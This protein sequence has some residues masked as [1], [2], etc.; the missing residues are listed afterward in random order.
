MQSKGTQGIKIPRRILTPGRACLKDIPDNLIFHLKRFDYDLMN[1]TRSKVNDYFEFPQEID[2]A[3]YNVEYLKDTQQVPT[4]DR[5]ILVGILVHSGNAEAGHY[6]SYIRERPGYRGTWVE[7]ND[8]D[9]TYFDP[10]FIRDQCFGGLFEQP[11]TG[12]QYPKTWNAYMLF[13]QRA[14]SMEA[15]EQRYPL[16]NASSPVRAIVPLELANHLNSE[17]EQWIR[18]FCLFD[19]EY[20]AFTRKVVEHYRKLRED[21]CSED[22]GLERD[23][24]HMIVHQLDMVFTREKDGH[25]ERDLILDCLW[26]MVE[27]CAL[28][29]E[30][31]LQRLVNDERTLRALILR[32]PDDAF[33][34][35]CQILLFNSLKLLK[36]RNL[37]R[38]SLE[39]DSGDTD[40]SPGQSM[41]MY[42][43][44]EPGL[45]Q[46]TILALR[47]LYSVMHLHSRMWDEYYLLL[48]KLA[49]I[50]RWEKSVVYSAGFLTYV[51]QILIGESRADIGIQWPAVELYLKARNRR[52]ISFKNLVALLTLLLK[53]AS[54]LAKTSD[55]DEVNAGEAWTYDLS[56][57]EQ[58]IIIHTSWQQDRPSMKHLTF[59]QGVFAANNI[60]TS[61][62]Q[63]L[64][65]TLV[66]DE[67]FGRDH[68]R[69]ICNTILRGTVV[70]PAALAAPYLSAGLA[71][72]ETCPEGGI[73][74]Q[75]LT[76]Y[77]KDVA[78]INDSGG[79]EHLEF[80][81]M[82]SDLYNSY[83]TNRHP[84]FFQNEIL[85]LVPTF[86]PHLLFYP[87]REVR[88]DTVDFLK[89]LIFDRDFGDDEILADRL[90]QSGRQLLEGCVRLGAELI[91]AR[92]PL[93]IHRVG[94][95]N[96]VTRHLFER[97]IQEQSEEWEVMSHQIR[98]MSLLARAESEEDLD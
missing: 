16:I 78:S 73:V 98:S 95:F 12:L 91:R 66:Q 39:L 94:D 69:H 20:A 3:P 10:A 43:L 93:E 5:F 34:K 25:I 19:P 27:R 54:D 70:E 74:K 88:L 41:Q 87:E 46:D 59:L 51:L 28:C 4:P 50:G 82:A 72:C 77:A 81:S 71:F 22:H 23:L 8:A 11:Y 32:C 42:N 17:N 30:I 1:G 47:G 37:R 38:Y 97:Y 29:C 75:L 58:D 67:R 48:I 63:D 9:V 2:M 44:H 85:K 64:V 96:R 14:S 15:E 49:S 76:K 53:G 79:S 40:S 55:S 86:A 13:Y 18:K 6:Y 26:K 56:V 24:I 21:Q 92:K 80:F 61:V 68:L 45:F 31:Y 52:R 7:M 65:R 62:I 83:I 57:E 60:E 84:N 36:E 89:A 90:D 33:R 35:R